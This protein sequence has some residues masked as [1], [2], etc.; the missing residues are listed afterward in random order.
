MLHS[1]TSLRISLRGNEV[2]Q[3]QF[4]SISIIFKVL[5]S[6]F[7]SLCVCCSFKVWVIS[8]TS[9][10]MGLKDGGIEKEEINTYIIKIGEKTKK[11]ED[12]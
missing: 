9:L 2:F 11:K 3:T 1:F 10:L 8:S 5:L 4:K 7:C 6:I 12:K